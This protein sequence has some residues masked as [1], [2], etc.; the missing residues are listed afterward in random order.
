MPSINIKQIT[1]LQ[2]KPKDFTL[3]KVKFLK[4]GMKVSCQVPREK[5]VLADISFA[6]TERPHPDLMRVLEKFKKPLLIAS[7]A[8]VGTNVLLDKK[9]TLVIDPKLPKKTIEDYRTKVI[10]AIA[11]S[12]DVKG[13]SFHGND[14]NEVIKINGGFNSSLGYSGLNTPN[15]L[16]GDSLMKHG[17]DY[18][19][20]TEAID[21]LRH[22]VY[23]WLVEGKHNVQ[24]KL[25]LD[26]E[27]EQGE[28]A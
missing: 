28:A 26:G 14:E 18:D 8:L 4:E 10:D 22:E 27:E 12:V 21:E 20:L 24:G 5:G 17:L 2:L 23:K 11:E 6:S 15:I 16:I 19:E 25:N 7:N 1:M 3:N 9:N 13:I